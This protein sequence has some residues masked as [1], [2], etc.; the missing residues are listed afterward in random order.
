MHTATPQPRRCDD[1]HT[2]W[3]Y[4]PEIGWHLEAEGLDIGEMMLAYQAKPQ[5]TIV[6]NITSVSAVSADRWRGFSGRASQHPARRDGVLV[7]AATREG[8]MDTLLIMGRDVSWLDKPLIGSTTGALMLSAFKE[9][10][11]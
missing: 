11:R 3:A 6:A 10:E 2:I 7:V 8:E 9:D 1:R 4:V 5:V